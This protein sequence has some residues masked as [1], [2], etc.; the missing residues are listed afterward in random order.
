MYVIMCVYLS[1][2]CVRFSRAGTLCVHLILMP[3]YSHIATM[4]EQT[5]DVSTLMLASF[6]GA[7]GLARKE[8]GNEATLMPDSVTGIAAVCKHGD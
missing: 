6:P 8:P 1:L 7:G 5:S 4:S 3:F 2:V